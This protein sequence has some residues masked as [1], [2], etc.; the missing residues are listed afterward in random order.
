MDCHAIGYGFLRL[1]YKYQLCIIFS[2]CHN[3]FSHNKHVPVRFLYTF[4]TRKINLTN[5]EN[6]L[7]SYLY[8]KR[9]SLYPD[10][11]D[12]LGARG[13][14]VDCPHL[15]H[16]P[17]V[18]NP[19]RPDGTLLTGSTWNQHDRVNVWSNVCSTSFLHLQNL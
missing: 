15:L 13:H 2:L 5:R 9:R 1:W 19:H 17:N 14:N 11:I 3:Y 4:I 7:T 10:N 12:I 8:P 18:S 6:F 16:G